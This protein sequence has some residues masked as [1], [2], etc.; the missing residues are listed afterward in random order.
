MN[1]GKLVF[2]QV[3]EHLPLHVFH[4]CVVRYSGPSPSTEASH[5]TN[6]DYRRPRA[7]VWRRRRILGSQSR[8]LVTRTRPCAQRESR[9][10]EV[11]ST[12]RETRCVQT[13]L[14]TRLRGMPWANP[15][16]S[17]FLF[18]RRSFAAGYGAISSLDLTMSQQAPASR[19]SGASVEPI[20]YLYDT[21]TDFYRLW[22]DRNL[23]YSAARWGGPCQVAVNPLSLE[24]AQE[25]KLDF[26]LS[27][28][29]RTVMVNPIQ[30]SGIP[31]AHSAA[32]RDAQRP[33]RRECRKAAVVAPAQLYSS[34]ARS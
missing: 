18:H 12:R 2:A 5:G 17:R 3:M 16:S 26:H 31:S 34:R 32:D 11:T 33:N 27:G 21:G 28:V 6:S 9:D 15:I 13:R 14:Q 30:T 20:S 7:A 1:L 19:P 22:L 8:L 25:A 4:R 24:L 23:T 29:S 10:A